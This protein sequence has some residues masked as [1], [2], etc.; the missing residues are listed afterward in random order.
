MRESVC[1]HTYNTYT[2]GGERDRDREPDAQIRREADARTQV[3]IH[4]YTLMHKFRHI[5][6]KLGSSTK[7]T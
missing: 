3:C 2:R 1:A 4:I 5:P 6:F 7:K